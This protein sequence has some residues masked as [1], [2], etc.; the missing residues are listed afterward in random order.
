MLLAV[1]EAQT[2]QRAENGIEEI[3]IGYYSDP[4]TED[5]DET[6]DLDVSQFS[7]LNMEET[8][9][10]ALPDDL[11]S[12]YLAEVHRMKTGEIRPASEFEQSQPKPKL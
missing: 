7:D 11:K 12:V 9:L 2:L 5:Q 3:V 4:D 6:Q 10:D 1:E 8:A